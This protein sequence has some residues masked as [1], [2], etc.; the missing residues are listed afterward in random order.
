MGIE[1]QRNAPSP[2]DARGEDEAPAYPLP[3]VKTEK[4]VFVNFRTNQL[5]TIE[6][7]KSPVFVGPNW[8]FIIE[9]DHRGYSGIAK[10][11]DGLYKINV[12]DGRVIEEKK[13][14]ERQARRIIK[15]CLERSE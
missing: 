12:V 10:R 8:I 1:P 5:I 11:S 4:K 14:T 7:A 13:I 3:Y 2:R 6:I 9:S 15:Q